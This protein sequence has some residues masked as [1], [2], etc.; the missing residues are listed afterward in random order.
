MAKQDNIYVKIDQDRGAEGALKK[1]KRMCESYGITKEYRKR[2]EFKKPS[3]RL[4]EKHEM[5]EK[6]RNKALSKFARANS[7]I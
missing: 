7:K 1:F 5:A 2:R 3:V 6:R 4:K